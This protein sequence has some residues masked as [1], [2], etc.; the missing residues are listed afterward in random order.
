MLAWG[1][2][3]APPSLL[4]HFWGLCRLHRD[5]ALTTQSQGGCRAS[6]DVL[7]APCQGT[8]QG[9]EWGPDSG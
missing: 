9:E 3:C 6:Q 4:L 2:P 8:H 1:V 5:A 7:P